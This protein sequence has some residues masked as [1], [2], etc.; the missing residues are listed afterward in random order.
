[1]IILPNYFVVFVTAC[2]LTIIISCTLLANNILISFDHPLSNLKH[3][4]FLIISLNN[5]P[6]SFPFCFLRLAWQTAS[7]ASRYFSLLMFPCFHSFHSFCFS[8]THIVSVGT[9]PP[10]KPQISNFFCPPGPEKNN[11]SP[12]P[13]KKA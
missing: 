12:Q 11:K 1:M 10:G 9:D 7:F 13:D 5:V 8:L 6:K 2:Q 4:A 3:S